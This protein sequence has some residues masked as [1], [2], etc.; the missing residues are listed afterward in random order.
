MGHKPLKKWIF[1]V[2]G[3]VLG[4]TAKFDRMLNMDPVNPMWAPMCP[5]GPEIWGFEAELGAIS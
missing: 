3:A 5:L 1:P 2:L 4:E